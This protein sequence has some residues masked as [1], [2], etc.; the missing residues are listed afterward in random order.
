[1]EIDVYKYE[2]AGNDC[3]LIDNRARKFDPQKD[4]VARLCH[5]RFGIGADGLMLL[6]EDGET[7]FR[8]RYFNADGL[9]ATMCGNGGR[10]IALFAEHL[11]IGG[12][13]KRFRAVDGIHDAKVTTLGPDRGEIALG[14]NDVSTIEPYAKGS[15]LDTGSPHYV[16]FVDRVRDIDV[17]R[18]GRAIR[19][20]SPLAEH[21][22]ANVNFDEFLAPDRI[23]IRTY[24]RGVED[25]TLACGTG[26]T[27]CAIVAHALRSQHCN[28]FDIETAGGKLNV[29]FS[30]DNQGTYRNIQLSGP[31][32]RVFYGTIRTENFIENE[33]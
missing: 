2:G 1:M 27:A 16:E 28:N 4:L 9:E 32:R 25:E 20:G 23:R 26:A 17:V 7:S 8:M 13:H 6:E 12:Y 33:S 10:C 30:V 14:M 24:E 15:L 22:G 18:Q 31:A 29:S 11:G 5:R 3:V 19:Y 21:G